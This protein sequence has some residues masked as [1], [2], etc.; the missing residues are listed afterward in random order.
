MLLSPR[1]LPVH[2]SPTRQP[3][4]AAPV[5]LSSSVNLSSNQPMNLSPVDRNSLPVNLSS[6]RGQT[7]SSQHNTQVNTASMVHVIP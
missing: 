3:A 4:Q 5:N 2:L 6:N 7:P 1:Q